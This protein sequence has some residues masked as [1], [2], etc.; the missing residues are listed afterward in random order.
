VPVK[1]AINGFGR[2]GRLAARRAASDDSLQLAGV[3]DLTDAKTLAHLFK[4]DSVHG[5]FPGEVNHTA[6]EIAIAGNAARVTAE[7]DP[8]RL[9]WKE[10]GVDIVIESTGAFRSL[11]KARAHIDAG[12]KKVIISAPAKGAGVKSFV[13]GINHD[14][15][16]PGEDHV[17]SNA[18]CTTNCVVPMAKVVHDNFGILK[19][20]MT[21]VH[22]YT[23]DQRILDL[24]HSDLR[25][26]RAAAL[27][28]IP[29]TTGAA[30]LIGI[31]FPELAGKVDGM[32]LRV[33][34]PDVSIVDLTCMIK[35]STSIDAVNAAFQTAAAGQL[36]GILQYCAD[37]LVSIDMVG[38]PHSSI[39]DAGLTSVVDG[40]LVKTFAWYDNE[41][42]Y[43]CRLIDMIRFMADK[44]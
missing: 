19:A 2:I 40:N 17:V 6:D 9:P 32:A 18:S 35:K 7:R 16:I 11:D 44:L 25:R 24:P 30:G 3:N 29:T 39:L 37:P 21:T 13:Y 4:Y 38:N 43:A 12:A 14:S 31:I 15:Y 5:T 23:G 41:Y 36:R 10:L 1:F 33:P 22:A 27:S 8:A 20:Y 26:A 28:M 42:G 34:T